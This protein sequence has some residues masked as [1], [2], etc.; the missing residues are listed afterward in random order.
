MENY[1]GDKLSEEEKGPI[2]AEIAG[3]FRS[4]P[5]ERLPWLRCYGLEGGALTYVCAD[6]ESGDWF[7]QTINWHR[8]G[9]ETVLKATE[10]KDI[11][12][13]V[14]M[15]LRTWDKQSKDT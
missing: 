15:T 2:M 1:P 9:K 10:A 6:Q 12:R 8:F 14:K 7:I 4:I 5:M 11:L 3:A 13:P